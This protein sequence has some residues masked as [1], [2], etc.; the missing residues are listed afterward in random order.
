MLSNLNFKTNYRNKGFTIIELLV[1]VSIATLVFA[2]VVPDYI[3]YLQRTRL[4]MGV[5]HIISFANEAREETRNGLRTNRKQFFVGVHI[6]P[7]AEAEI[8]LFSKD[9]K[10]DFT[11]SD[12]IFSKDTQIIRQFSLPR[13]IK[14][15]NSNQAS[16]DIVF[17]PP[18]GYLHLA[19]GGREI[20]QLILKL[21]SA[22]NLAQEIYI[23]ATSG[24]IK[25]VSK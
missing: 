16:I 14:F 8:K 5:E 4:K 6:D 15:A 2:L 3:N 20:S 7:T 10:K 18:R 21:I 24:Q 13:Q 9:Y 12:W 1:V 23:D 17:E 22:N 11:A 19:E 25:V